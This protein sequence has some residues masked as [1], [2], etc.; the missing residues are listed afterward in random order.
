MSQSLGEDKEGVGTEGEAVTRVGPGQILSRATGS[1]PGTT[2][3]S[4]AA[5]VLPV[6]ATRGPGAIYGSSGVSD[7]RGCEGKS[8]ETRQGLPLGECFLGGSVWSHVETRGKAALTPRPWVGEDACDGPGAG[9]G[10]RVEHCGVSSPARRTCSLR[11]GPAP[12]QAVPLGGLAQCSPCSLQI[13][14]CQFPGGALAHS[15]S[16]HL[17][18]PAQSGD[19]GRSLPNW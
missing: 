3:K 8:R 19:C 6:P 7:G 15:I 9:D 1:G 10:K 14:G 18:S 12:G 16:G 5:A 13:L 11:V 17:R 2:V 4:E